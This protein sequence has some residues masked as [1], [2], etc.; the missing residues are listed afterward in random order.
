MDSRVYPSLRSNCHQQIVY[1]QFDL[2]VF[3]LP[4]Y[5]RTVWYFSQVTYDHIKIVIK[6]Y[7][8]KSSLNNHDVN[9]QVPLFSKTIMNS[10]SNF[11]PNELITCDDQGWIALW[12]I[13]FAVINNFQFI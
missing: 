8:W 12:K 6:L 1:A 3:Y 13:L 11:V 5:E 9:E 7:D 10:M 4:L 2:K